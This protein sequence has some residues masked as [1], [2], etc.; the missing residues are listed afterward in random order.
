MLIAR[1]TLNGSGDECTLNEARWAGWPHLVGVGEL[2]VIE[3]HV[4]EVF[5]VGPC[6]PRAR[7]HLDEGSKG[8]LKRSNVVWG[9]LFNSWFR[10]SH[11]P[12]AGSTG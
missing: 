9:Q 12:A 7:M 11:V 6:M 5:K 1:C 8:N 10:N 4:L 3:V 2:E